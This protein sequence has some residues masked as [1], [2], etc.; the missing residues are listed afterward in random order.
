MPTIV[1]ICPYCRAGGVRAPSTALGA[2][3]VCPK[4]KSHF[5]IVP[6]EDV[7]T[8]WEGSARKPV[9]VPPP[10]PASAP[11]DETR[12]TA[13]MPD[14]TEPSPVLPDEGGKKGK[15]KRKAK[16]AAVP[17]PEAAE[18]DYS[19]PRPDLATVG[20]LGAL[21]LVGPVV[22][23]SQLPFGRFIAA[24][25]ALAGLVGGLSCLAAEGQTRKFAAAAAVL[26]FLTLVVVV[27]LPSWLNLDPWVPP[28]PPEEPKGPVAVEHGSTGGAG[29]LVSPNDWLDAGKFAWQFRD[30]R[31]TVRTGVG[32]VELHGPKDAKRATKEQ[33]LH[34][35]LQVRNVG[36]DRE[37]P[38]TGWAAGQGAD[39]V[40]VTD[41]NGKPL[42][43]ATFEGGW[44][45]EPPKPVGRAM[46][47]QA[48]EVTLLFAAP[49]AKTEF[50]RVQ[51]AG[52]AVG[53]PDTEIKFR[54]GAAGVIP[55]GTLP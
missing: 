23:A 36:F 19:A 15:G 1:A 26:H 20:A 46:P 12:A 31:V 48:P 11:L 39:G 35:T 54:T 17:I 38:L 32:P 4:C 5:T 8:D 22:L 45:P 43:P 27:F 13:A 37:L 51:L 2:S 33:Y 40:R 34:L 21:I 28:A 55:R 41:P 42:A 25:L 52:A 44:R 7:P 9:P 30:T 6:S 29:A 50:V 14:V 53:V 24:A 16:P 47:G 49:P 10:A 3:A 18:R